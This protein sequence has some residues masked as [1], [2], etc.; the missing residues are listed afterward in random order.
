VLHIRPRARVVVVG[1]AAIAL[2][3]VGA[4]GTLAASNPATLYACYNVYGVVR[5]T[6]ANTCKLPGGGRL[7]SWGT[8]PAGPTG[9]QGAS[10]PTGP[11]GD[12]GPA[13]PTGAAGPTG[14]TGATGLVGPAGGAPFKRYWGSIPLGSSSAWITNDP[15][16]V[17]FWIKCSAPDDRL[18]LS[19][20]STTG[21]DIMWSPT[22]QF[23]AGGGGPGVIGHLVVSFVTSHPFTATATAL[24]DTVVTIDGVVEQA[25]DSSPCLYDFTGPGMVPAP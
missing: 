15:A 9:P 11:A 5:M 22:G 12:T 2:V 7:V 25:T 4:G 21:I 18:E 10:G 3:A 19:V 14:P 6:D 1:A 13:G 17:N 8:G 23:T 24:D 16:G 20:D